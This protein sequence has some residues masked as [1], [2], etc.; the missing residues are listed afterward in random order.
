MNVSISF[1]E[2]QITGTLHARKG[3]TITKRTDPDQFELR[4]TEF[5]SSVLRY[6]EAYDTLRRAILDGR[7]HLPDPWRVAIDHGVPIL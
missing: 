5:P 7:V 2:Q 4:L 1:D 6:E 3:E